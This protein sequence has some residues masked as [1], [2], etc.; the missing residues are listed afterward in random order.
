V[1]LPI[2]ILLF[3]FSCRQSP[4][5]TRQTA[6]DNRLDTLPV[7]TR[8]PFD[9]KVKKYED[10]TRQFWQDPSLVLNQL[11]DLQGKVV[12]DI[13]SGTGYFTFQLAGAAKKVIAIDIEQR[14][15]DYI[16]DRKVELSNKALANKIETRLIS[17]DDPAIFPDEVDNVLMV[18]TFSYIENRIEY[19][20]K[21]KLG[22]KTGG[23]LV[24]V[25]YKIGDIPVGP[26]AGQKVS[27]AQA[28]EELTTA[29]FN[30]M[31][32]DSVSLQYQYII[33]SRK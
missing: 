4:D 8:E 26:A 1:R 31:R 12:A 23:L 15:L 24:I 30:V 13:G 7:T 14:F 21:I 19:L 10:P 25:D 2:L 11:G 6:T 22:M 9:L 5:S 16:E 17:P 3:I 28:I 18:N 27:M 29:S 32:S 33:T 20:D